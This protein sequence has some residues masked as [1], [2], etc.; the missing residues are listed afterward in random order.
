VSETQFLGSQQVRRS[1][2]AEKT[3]TALTIYLGVCERDHRPV[4]FEFPADMGPSAQI[5]CPQCTLPVSGERLHAVTTTLTCDGS[6]R[7]ARRPWCECGCGGI[8]HGNIWTAGALIDQREVVESALARYRAGQ[9]RIARRQRAGFD[10][11]AAEHQDVIT[12]LGAWYEHRTDDAWQAQQG[13]WGQHILVQF[14]IQ[15][16]GGPNGTPKPLTGAQIQLTQRIL[17]EQAEH[18][19]AQAEQAR[20]D[21]A[22]AARGAGDQST[23]VPGVYRRGGDIFVVKGNKAYTSW[24]KHN[25][26]QPRPAE[27]RLYAKRLTESPARQTEAGTVIPFELEYAPGAIYDLALADRLPLAGAEQLATRY[28]KCIACGATLKAAKSVREAIGPVCRKY[29]G[30]VLDDHKQP[31]AAS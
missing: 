31:E 23:L 26:G 9:A 20:R 1:A 5:P 6:C 7:S 28:G 21:A 11:W 25:P 13:G 15:T 17:R 12:A 2:Y 18:R 8:N 10:R 19:R 3:A 27:A 14:A 16:H 30:P 22:R 29:F 24:R 4:R